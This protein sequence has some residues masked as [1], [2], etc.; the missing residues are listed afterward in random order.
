MSWLLSSFS[1]RFLLLVL[2]FFS[3]SS[4]SFN[5]NGATTSTPEGGWVSLPPIGG[6]NLNRSLVIKEWAIQPF[7]VT[8]GYDPSQVKRAIILFPGKPRDS[9]KYTTLMGN[10]LNVTVNGNHTDLTD[11]GVK[12]NEV[13]ILGPA[14][15]NQLDQQV[16]R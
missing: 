15:L 10:A 5:P 8:A 3:L 14:W 7:Y 12:Y 16:S 2:N 11:Q 6:F 1:S 13:I 9:W 4:L